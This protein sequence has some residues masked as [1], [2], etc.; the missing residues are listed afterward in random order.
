MR[1]FVYPEKTRE[2]LGAKRW[3]IS[4]H[5]LKDAVKD[6]AEI[7]FDAD[8]RERSPSFKTETEARA[9]AARVLATGETFFGVVTLQEQAVDW[10]VEEDGVAEW[11]D[12][13]SPE[14]IETEKAGK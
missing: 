12:V 14:E 8:L 11:T 4:W 13:G 5:E 6:G 9:A 2:E 10:F 1:V 3:Q 7:N